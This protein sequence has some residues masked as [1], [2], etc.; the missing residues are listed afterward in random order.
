MN[1]YKE[2]EK[3]A[4]IVLMES[5]RLN[6]TISKN[7]SDTYRCIGNNFMHFT[8]DFTDFNDPIHSNPRIIIFYDVFIL[9]DCLV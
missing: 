6:A 5:P 7:P 2:E 3:H 9:F 1:K 4:G 8:S